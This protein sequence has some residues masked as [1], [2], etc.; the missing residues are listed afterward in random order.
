MEAL[1][2][3][4]RNIYRERGEAWLE[5][6]PRLIDQLRQTW[7][8][9]EIM[10]VPNI[11][12]HFVAKAFGEHR[13]PVVLKISCERKTFEEEVR[14]LQYFK[15]RGVV[16]LLETE[17]ECK[18]MLLQ[19][20]IPGKSL[21]EQAR[22]KPDSVM[23]EYIKAI[24][25]LH[26]KIPSKVPAGLPIIEDWFKVFDRIGEG[27]LPS[28]LSIKAKKLLKERLQEGVRVYFLHGDLHLGNIVQ[29]GEGWLAID[30]QGVVGPLEFELS[31]FDFTDPSEGKS[32]L[33]LKDLLEKRI[34]HLATLAKVDREKLRDWVFLRLML[35]V[36]WFIEDKGDPSRHLHLAT[37]LA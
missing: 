11:S 14:A 36:S 4:I 23:E 7:K 33:I 8:L 22:G 12:Y 29:N 5:Q 15:G 32:D 10:P 28:R 19:Q 3:N 16:K 2:K 18:A 37:L 27:S 31:A 21:K 1:Q 9:N 24:E 20:A 17:N 25:K 34:E 13:L 35:S 6:L 26:E 30:P